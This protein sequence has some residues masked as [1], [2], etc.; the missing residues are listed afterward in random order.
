MGL[1]IHALCKHGL[2]ALVDKCK[3]DKEALEYLGF[4]IGKDGITMHPKKLEMIKSWPVLKMVKEVQSF[5]GFTNFYC[6]FISH[7]ST[8][9]TPPTASMKKN[10]SISFP[11]T[12]VPLDSFLRLKNAFTST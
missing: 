8:I 7:Y 5:L 4:I 9:S 3:F 10:N 11:L 6:Q 12:G 2:L 1:D